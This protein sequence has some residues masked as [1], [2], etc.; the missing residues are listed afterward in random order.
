MKLAYLMNA[1]PMTSTTFIRREIQA[2]E[3]AGFNINRYAIRT[4]DQPLV[5]PKDIEEKQGTYYI[6]QQ[7][8]F[9][10]L[11]ALCSGWVRPLECPSDY[12]GCVGSGRRGLYRG[13]RLTGCCGD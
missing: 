8:K 12:L 4:W 1:Y 5:D 2:H 11:A 6:L 13:P 7:S 10:I 3:D 9:S